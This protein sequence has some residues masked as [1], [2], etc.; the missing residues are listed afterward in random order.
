MPQ[1]GLRSSGR[2]LSGTPSASSPPSPRSS[3]PYSCFF[4]TWNFRCTLVG[5]LIVPPSPT[6][7]TVVHPVNSS[8]NRVHLDFTDSG[9]PL[10]LQRHQI[11]VDVQKV[12]LA[13]T[14]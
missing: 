2:A 3:I 6:T 9:L 11:S 12:M 10:P 1:S 8:T 5:R 13:V 14:L 4:S 7:Y